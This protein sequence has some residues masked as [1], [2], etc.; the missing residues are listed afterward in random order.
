VTGHSY[1]VYR[2]LAN[3]ATTL[4]FEG[5]PNYPPCLAWEVCDKHK[6]QHHLHRAHGD[7]R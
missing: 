2:P 7:P 1:I 3:G 6:G 5:V 4:M